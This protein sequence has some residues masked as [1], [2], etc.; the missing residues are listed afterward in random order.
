MVLEKLQHNSSL[1]ML[2]LSSCRLTDRSASMLSLFLKK[3]KT[4]LLQSVWKE[5]KIPRDDH[6]IAVRILIKQHYVK[7][8]CTLWY[9]ITKFS[10]VALKYF[11]GGRIASTDTQRELQ[12]RQRWLATI[13]T[14]AEKRLLV[15]KVVS[16][17]LRDHSTRREKFARASA[18]KQ[19]AYAHWSS[20]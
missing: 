2:N 16:T 7:Y 9:F 14:Y 1:R 10:N 11:S 5:S 8:H 20:R 17:V 19:H 15:E 6:P 4:D 3:R 12:I 18:N 13:D